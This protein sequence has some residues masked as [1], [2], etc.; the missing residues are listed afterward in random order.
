MLDDAGKAGFARDGFLVRE[1]FASRQACADLLAQAARLVDGFDPGT[2][3]S[4]FTTT[5]QRQTTDEYF[6]TSGGTIRFFFEEG[7][8]DG[9]GRLVRE[10]ALALNKIGHALHDL[11]PVFDRFSRDGRLA[12]LAAG[13]GIGRPL[14][15]QS[16]YIFKQAGVGGEVVAH[17]DATFLVTDPP[18]VVG[19][20]FALEDANVENGCLFVLPGGH[21]LGLKRRFRRDGLGSVAMDVLDAAPW[22]E[23]AFV[24][25]EVP[26][27]T[28]VVLHGLLPHR[29]A[30]NRSARSRQAYTLHVI[31]G[32]A[33]W[34]DD[35]WL[36]RPEGMPAR[37]FG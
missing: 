21:R 37:G 23:D 10:K 12:G 18:S 27:G 28:L 19:F 25:L 32:A 2:V 5:R 29:S 14:L 22:P 24:P 3:R 6:L 31:D 33:T 13:L 34:S 35:N 15:I 30:A 17:Q 11:D 36:T 20:W 7:A 16:M 1:G 26:A 9:E 4:V 8:L